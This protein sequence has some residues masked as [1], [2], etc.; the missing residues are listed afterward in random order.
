VKNRLKLMI[1]GLLCLMA[2]VGVVSA[3]VA[4]FTDR[5]MTSSVTCPDY[6]IGFRVED[7]PDV[8]VPINPTF[9]TDGTYC[10]QV[11]GTNCVYLHFYHIGQAGTDINAFDF[12]A[13]TFDVQ[14]VVVKGSTKER[15]YD[16]STVNPKPVTADTLLSTPP[17]VV[18]GNKY[19]AISH[20][21]FCGIA[22]PEFP[23]IAVPVGMLI[24]IVGIVYVVRKRED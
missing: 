24:G 2:F 9:L 7:K 11:T 6:S 8:T 17:F 21:N 5:A 16:Y 15:V 10:D 23:T 3:A 20:I 13:A 18:G 14:E 22:T 4:P 12:S 19:P 1:I